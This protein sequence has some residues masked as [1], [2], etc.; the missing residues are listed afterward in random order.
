MA[1]LDERV[2]QRAKAMWNDAG[3]PPGGADAYIDQA[4][5]LVAIE[6]NQ[7]Q[8]TRPLKASERGSPDE[9]ASL[10]LDEAGPTG[11]PVEPV[12]ALENAGEFPTMTDQGEEQAPHR[13]DEDSAGPR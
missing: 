13:E 3:R 8:A 12:I 7:M 2:W 11:E 1:N 10:T 5:E 6:D 9:G 4:S